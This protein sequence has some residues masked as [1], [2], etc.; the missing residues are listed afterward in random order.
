MNGHAVTVVL[1]ALACGGLPAVERRPYSRYEGIVA[2][3][4]FGAPPANFD[5]SVNPGTISAREAARAEKQLSVEQEQLKRAVKFS[6]INLDP[7]GVVRVGFSDTS[8]AKMPRHYYL[9]AGESRDGWRVVAADAAARTAKIE[10]D[11]VELD[12]VLGGE[13]S[14]EA[15]P[16]PNVASARARTSTAPENPP[17]ARPAADVSAKE[18]LLGASTRMRQ[19]RKMRADELAKRE[20]EQKAREEE[21]KRERENMRE[22]LAALR[23]QL[24]EV[25]QAKA[26]EKAEEAEPRSEPPADTTGSGQTD[27]ESADAENAE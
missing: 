14:G 18:G 22:D 8:S 21:A 5:P 19:R 9:A 4:P 12:L 15:T 23:E 13:A 11:G 2:R 26:A 24:R 25:R 27:A 17:A 7:A 6:V 10:K 3:A 20:A 16:N 1:F